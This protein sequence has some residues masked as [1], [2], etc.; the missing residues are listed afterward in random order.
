MEELLLTFEKDD[1]GLYH[2]DDV[3]SALY[4]AYDED[5]KIF[6]KDE[7]SRNKMTCW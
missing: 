5:D 6:E 7:N 2:E 3:R 4:D 1:S